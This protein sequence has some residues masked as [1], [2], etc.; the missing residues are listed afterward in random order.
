MEIRLKRYDSDPGASKKSRIPASFLKGHASVNSIRQLRLRAFSFSLTAI[1]ALSCA[2]IAQTPA[3]QTAGSQRRTPV[4]VELFTSEGCSS[5]P[6]ADA[7]LARL[8]REQPVSTAEIIV[9][10]EHVDYWEQDGWH[11]RFSSS[12][13]TD[14]QNQYAPR[15]KFDSAYTPQMVVDGTT[16]FV[17]NNSP[18]AYRAVVAAA[19]TP[20]IALTLSPPVIDG[21]HVVCSVSSPASASPLP[22]ADLFAALVQ[23]TATTE[24]LHGENGGRHLEHVGIVRSL[25]RIGKLQDLASGP[26]KFS[27]NAPADVTPTNMRVVVF[28]Q[29]S[30]QGPIRGAAV[31]ATK[32]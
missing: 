22:K 29:G 23:P 7:L 3:T 24:V 8:D 26:V 17:G 1:V 13:Y 27:I 12:Q 9:L 19:Q 5:C 16:Q 15:L 31:I 18:R 20:K 2:T 6:P 25:Q 10:E 21:R 30:G 11:D 32:Q 14:R 28:A 4:I